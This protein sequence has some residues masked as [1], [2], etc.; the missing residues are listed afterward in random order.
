[1]F[2]TTELLLTVLGLMLLFAAASLLY[3]LSW[4]VTLTLDWVLSTLF[5]LATR[6]QGGARERATR[7][8]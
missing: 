3:A 2:G 4:A 5:R 8:G 6:V 1:M 7:R